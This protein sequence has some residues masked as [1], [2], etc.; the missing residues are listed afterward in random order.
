[1]T[2]LRI[3]ITD[4][5]ISRLFQPCKRYCTLSGVSDVDDWELVVSVLVV[6]TDCSGVVED[7]TTWLEVDDLVVLTVD[8]LAI[9]VEA[10]EDLVVACG[11]IMLIVIVS[12]M[13]ANVPVRG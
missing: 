13:E 5:R 12:R 8:D 4:A 3:T 1:M 2:T 10:V 7:T 9:V 11:P 6:A